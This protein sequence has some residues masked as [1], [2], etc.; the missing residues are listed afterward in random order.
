[1]LAKDCWVHNSEPSYPPNP[2][3]ITGLT[4]GEGYLEDACFGTTPATVYVYRADVYRRQHVVETL[5]GTKYPS[6]VKLG[7]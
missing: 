6:D 5:A 3:N 4:V 2:G 7:P 1:I